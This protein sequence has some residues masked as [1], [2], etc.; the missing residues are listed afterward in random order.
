V[1]YTNKYNIPNEIIRSITNDGYDSGGA[2]LSATG[3]LQPPQ[4]R[5]L[6]REHDSEI[7]TDVSDRIWILLGTSVHNILERANEG[8]TETLTEQRM[9]A[10]I[11]GYKIS[12]QTDSI[13]IED[14]IVKDYK[15]TSV[16]SVLSCQKKIKPEWEQQLNIYAYLYR[17]NHKTDVSAL[18]IIAIMRDWS[19][20]GRLRNKDYPKCAVEVIPIP[21][22]SEEEQLDFIKERIKIHKTAD[23]IFDLDGTTPECTAEERWAKPDTYAVMKKGRKSALRLLPTEE[24]AENF[25]KDYK[26]SKDLS[27][28]F[29]KGVSTRC[30]G[31]CEVSQFCKQYKESVNGGC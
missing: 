24:Q 18:N 5:I 30:E 12:G 4:I 23:L 6:K 15:I 13:S 27:I 2:D 3:L 14:K 10:Q 31:Y 20:N 25:M 8:N 16:W 17:L 22:W 9:F 21:L 19:K 7:T 29:R 26:V 28:D 1:K 11:D